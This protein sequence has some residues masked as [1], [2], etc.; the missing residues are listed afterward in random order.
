VLYFFYCFFI[1]AFMCKAGKLLFVFVL[2]AFMFVLFFSRSS[3][4]FVCFVSL[5]WCHVLNEIV[6]VFIGSCRVLDELQH[7]VVDR[8]RLSQADYFESPLPCCDN[9][10]IE[11]V[12]AS[13]EID[14]P[15][16]DDA[17]VQRVRAQLMAD[18]D[19][20]QRA[21]EFPGFDGDAY[22]DEQQMACASPT[23]TDVDAGGLDDIEACISGPHAALTPAEQIAWN[24]CEALLCDYDSNVRDVVRAAL[25]VRN[26]AMVCVS[27]VCSAAL[28]CNTAALP[29]GPAHKAKVVL[30]YMVEYLNKNKVALRHAAAIV[31]YALD[32]MRAH[33]STAIDVGTEMRSGQHLLSIIL[34]KLNGLFELTNTQAAAMATGMHSYVSTARTRY[35][36]IKAAMAC[37]REHELKLEGKDNS[38]VWEVELDN[39]D[40]VQDD[41]GVDHD[42]L[43]S[44][45]HAVQG[46]GDVPSTSTHVH[47]HAS[48][49]VGDAGNV[50]TGQ[51]IL[52]GGATTY[53]IKDAFGR[54][55]EVIPVASH[56][57][58]M[59]RGPQLGKMCFLEYELTVEVVEIPK[60]STKGVFSFFVF[61]IVGCHFFT[62]FL[63]C[64]SC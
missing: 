63:N 19:A 1:F 20:D 48:S 5:F 43:V 13:P 9:R 31:K 29:L 44:I 36:F 54:V 27:P 37:V 8:V 12:M 53:R 3:A 64:R 33:P 52:H 25:R 35:I 21:Y 17:T 39:P 30:F 60:V 7:Q 24:E 11:L 47:M 40:V 10:M 18:M 58:Y 49:S 57:N 16:V 22:M 45:C 59:Y 61:H 56:T 4:T 2:Y 50:S 32:K 62:F 41:D 51:R 38:H 15:V 26:S 28:G 55:S 34:N 6:Y 23:M 46:T 42:N 14:V